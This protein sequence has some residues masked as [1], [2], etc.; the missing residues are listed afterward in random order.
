MDPSSSVAWWADWTIPGSVITQ[1][2]A[3]E[4]SFASCNSSKT[5]CTITGTID[6]DYTMVA[7]VEYRL[8]GVVKVGDGNVEITSQA[9]YDLSLIHI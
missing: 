3:E 9:E 1:E 2:V 8:D 5:E 7:G 6:Q 4:T